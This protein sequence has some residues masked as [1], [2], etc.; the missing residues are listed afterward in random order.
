[1]KR[2]VLNQVPCPAGERYEKCATVIC[3]KTCSHLKNPPPCPSVTPDCFD[4]ACVCDEE[5][6]R[7]DEGICVPIKQCHNGEYSLVRKLPPY[8]K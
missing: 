2:L 8:D 3:Y 1:M 4:P 6:L 7:N 5:S